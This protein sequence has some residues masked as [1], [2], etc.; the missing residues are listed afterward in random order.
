MKAGRLFS[1]KGGAGVNFIR[2]RPF[3]SNQSDNASAAYTVRT[4][5]PFSLLSGAT[6]RGSLQT[7]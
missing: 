2:A 1:E 6:H 4:A 3:K 7:R 5:H